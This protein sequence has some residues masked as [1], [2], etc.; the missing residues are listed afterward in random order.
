VTTQGKVGS[1]CGNRLLAD[2][3]QGDT[4][5]FKIADSVEIKRDS[6][7]GS[8]VEFKNLFHRNKTLSPM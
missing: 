5:S 8:A 4:I 3:T 6:L 1:D 7:I 2:I